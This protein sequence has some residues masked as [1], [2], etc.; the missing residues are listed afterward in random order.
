M[1]ASKYPLFTQKNDPSDADIVSHKLMIRG[2]FI[3]QQSSG[4]Y[5]LMPMGIRVLKKIE[6]IIRRQMENIGCLEVL[7]PS[8]QP[9]ELWIQSGRW[10]NYGPELLRLQDRHK[11]DYCLGPT[12]EEVITDLIKKDL[13]SYKQLPINLFQISSKFR[14]E[15]RPRFGLMRAREFI[16]KD[17][18][19][20]HL[21]RE[22][23]DETYLKY[24]SAYKNI[25]DEIGLEYTIVDA[26]SGNIGGS[27]SHEFHVLADTGE[28]DLLID[29]TGKGVNLEIAK[30]KYDSDDV[31]RI[32]ETNNL[33]HKKGI[34]VG[35]IFKLGTKYSQSMDLSILDAE[36]KKQTIEMGCYGIGVS[37]IMS[38]A[39]EQCHDKDGINWPQCIAP[40]EL[41][42]IEMD[43]S[44]NKNVRDFSNQLYEQ[45]MDKKVEVLIDDRDVKLGIKLNDWE[46]IGAPFILIIGKS[47]AE[48]NSLTLKSKQVSGEK[49][50]VSFD[51]LLKLIES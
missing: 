28:D 38:A 21:N 34:E 35:H 15:I 20:F 31:A 42:I 47:E 13:N 18:Y 44:K 22:C 48:N 24:K 30:S 25:F 1:R 27:E 26:D 40:F 19:S 51:E 11:R 46:L 43:G 16:M 3:R 17:A 8:V 50:T 49:V 9:A 37:R 14:D 41:I 45:F 5:T 7:M 4:Q 32:K 12:F 23:L 33:I 10:D 6:K 29:E 39:I 2:G 36:S